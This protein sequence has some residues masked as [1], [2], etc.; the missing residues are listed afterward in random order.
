MLYKQGDGPYPDK[1]T[2]SPVNAANHSCQLIRWSYQAI[3]PSEKGASKHNLDKLH[4]QNLI[5]L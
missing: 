1:D 2:R 4:L 5:L 3:N